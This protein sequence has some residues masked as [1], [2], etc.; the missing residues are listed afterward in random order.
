M[1]CPNCGGVNLRFVKSY[2]SKDYDFTER[3]KICL[4]CGTGFKTKEIITHIGV[5]KAD[6][7]RLIY[8]KIE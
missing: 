6:K 4:D 5:Y 2:S 3:L 1:N 8:E 7:K